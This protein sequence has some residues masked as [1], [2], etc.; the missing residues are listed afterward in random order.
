MRTA[1]SQTW[2]KVLCMLFLPSEF[3][4]HVASPWPSTLTI[5]TIIHTSPKRSL[6][7][8]FSHYYFVSITYFHDASYTSCQSHPTCFKLTSWKDN[9]LSTIK[10]FLPFMESEGS[11]P[12]PQQLATNPHQK[13]PLHPISS[14]NVSVASS[15]LLTGLPGALPSGTPDHNFCKLRVKS[16]SNETPYYITNTKFLLFS[17]LRP[18]CSSVLG[19]QRTSISVLLLELETKIRVKTNQYL[20]AL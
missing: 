8:K 17:L 19:S 3:E 14:R 13:S 11:I 1:F 7:V 5:L 2:A 20:T 18:I 9:S 6:S 15:H 16:A 4:E 12:C 10:Q